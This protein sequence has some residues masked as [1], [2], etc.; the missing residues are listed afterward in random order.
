MLLGIHVAKLLPFLHRAKMAVGDSMVLSCTLTMPT[1]LD[2]S[3]WPDRK[4]LLVMFR[5]PKGMKGGD[6]LVA[7][8]A[9]GGEKPVRSAYINSEMEPVPL[10]GGAAYVFVTDNYDKRLWYIVR[11]AGGGRTVEADPVLSKID[12]GP[13]GFDVPDRKSV[14]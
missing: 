11:C 14:V 2:G 6:L 4:P 13:S 5:A 10:F 7:E 3:D 1:M 9:P 12:V 8:P